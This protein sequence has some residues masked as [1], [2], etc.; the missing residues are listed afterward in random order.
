MAIPFPVT[1]TAF[2]GVGSNIDPERNIPAALALLA[3]RVR[4]TGCSR[5]Y[6]SAPVGPPG[7]PAFVNGVWRVET[8]LGPRALKEGVL[9][10]IERDLGRVRTADRYAPRPIDL[11]LIAYDELVRSEPGLELPDPELRTRAF[12][13]VP[14]LEL[15]PGFSL[16]G[17]GELLAD[18]V[19]DEAAGALEPAA[20]LTAALQGLLTLGRPAGAPQ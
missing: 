10:A 16:P 6:R 15:A 8:A 19:D 12:L 1:A 4:V 3:R 13:Q 11:D 2:V 18:L 17:T 20:V 14:L 9:R 5:L 7:Q